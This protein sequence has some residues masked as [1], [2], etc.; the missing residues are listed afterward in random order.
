MK[1]LVK[2]PNFADT[3]K[4]KITQVFLGADM[5]CSHYGLSVL[6]KSYGIDTEKL[7]KNHML[8]FINRAQTHLKVYVSGNII[9]HTKRKKISLDAIK[10]I[11]YAFSYHGKVDY[12]S[13]LKIS[14]EK[15]LGIE[16]ETVSF[17]SKPL[18]LSSMRV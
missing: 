1:V 15:Q 4:P 18:G 5:R 10:E 8:V 9:A 11:P 6:A 16:K 7:P 2:K 13:A 14:L 17:S 12:D 3:N